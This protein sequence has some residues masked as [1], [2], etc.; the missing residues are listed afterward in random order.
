MVTQHINPYR[1]GPALLGSSPFVTP[2][3][4][5]WRHTASPY[6]PL[7]LKLAGG[8]VSISGDNVV[9][10]IL[11]MRGLEIIGVVLMGLA[12]P[13][14][15]QSVGKDRMCA[16][17][18]CLQSARAHP[19]H[20]WR[21]QY[22]LMVGPPLCGLAVAATK[23]PGAGASCSA[24]WS[25]DQS[26][27]RDRRRLHCRRSGARAFLPGRRLVEFAGSRRSASDRSQASRSRPVKASAG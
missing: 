13:K 16:M 25:G 2:V 19:F 11:T 10:A 1:F 9:R 4:Q 7:F 17:A 26:T 15:A 27:R 14:L 18:R 12:L 22:A 6:G 8:A 24:C 23:H 3:G 21:A 20:R 5:V